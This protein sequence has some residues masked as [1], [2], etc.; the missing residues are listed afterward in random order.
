MKSVSRRQFNT[1]VGI[2]A[3]SMLTSSALFGQTKPR[4]VIISGGVAGATVAA[5]NIRGDLT[6]SRVSPAQYANTC[7][8]L[9]S[10]DNGVKVG[11]QYEAS[12]DGQIVA[13]STFVSKAGECAETR[14]ISYQES[15][16][17]YDAITKDMFG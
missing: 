17:W 12:E 14:L 13:T 7:W 2:G 4:V 16:G 6:D 9:I 11:A 8:S 1:L 10:P 15:V 3:A 5:M